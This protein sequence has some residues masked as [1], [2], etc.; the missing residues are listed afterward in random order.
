MLSYNLEL[1]SVSL[2]DLTLIFLKSRI[3]Y[4]DNL[5]YYQVFFFMY[6]HLIRFTNVE[7]SVQHVEKSHTT[8]A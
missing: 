4:Q 8:Q 3:L 7:R 5:K 1:F 2:H 6:F